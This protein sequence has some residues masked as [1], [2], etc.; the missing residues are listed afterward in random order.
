MRHGIKVIAMS[1]RD[2]RASQQKSLQERLKRPL[3]RVGGFVFLLAAA[4]PFWNLSTRLIGSGDG[5]APFVVVFI[6]I[7]ACTI[8][9]SASY[10]CIR[11]SFG[12]DA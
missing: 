7:M 9:L 2:G 11:V 6:N 10:Y 4:M 12:G 1:E 3:F 8:L 5:G